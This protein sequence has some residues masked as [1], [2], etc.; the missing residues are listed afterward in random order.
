MMGTTRGAELKTTLT[1]SE[2]T[3][4][5][6]SRCCDPPTSRRQW[7]ANRPRPLRHRRPRSGRASRCLLH[8]RR[9]PLGSA[10]SSESPASPT[11]RRRC[12]TGWP[13]TAA[14]ATR[15]D[16]QMLAIPPRLQQVRSSAPCPL[17]AY[18]IG[19]SGG[20]ER[21]GY[22]VE[23]GTRGGSMCERT[24]WDPP[25]HPPVRHTNTK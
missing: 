12:R 24:V 13:P 16:A 20:C 1:P 10:A 7:H 3:T 2:S 11:W 22:A 15:C 18:G 25:P 4:T 8:A 17:R 6:G 14:D 5:S 23:E 19:C 21:T 9:R